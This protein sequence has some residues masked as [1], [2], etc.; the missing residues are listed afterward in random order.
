MISDIEVSIQIRQHHDDGQAS[1]RTIKTLTEIEEIRNI[2]STWQSNPISDIDNFLLLAR[3][4][5]EIQRPHVMVVY[6]NG[7]PDCVLVGRMEY[8]PMNFK[9]GY[10]KVFESRVKTLCFMHGGFL[11]NQSAENSDFL[12]REIM[13]ALKN[14]EADVARMES[15]RTDSSLG[16]A[17]TRIPGV[18]CR[19]HFS[20]SEIHGCL[21]LP[22]SYQAFLSSLPR[23]ERQNLKRYEKRLQA[24]FSGS[25]RIRCFRRESEIE[26]L[27]RDAEEIAKKTYQRGLGVGFADTPET[28]ETIQMA[29]RRGTLRACVL[30]LAARPCAFMIGAQYRDT[31][32]GNFLAFDPQFST[33]APGSLLLMHWI[34]E[35]FEANGKQQISQIDLGSG[36]AR[37]KRMICNLDWNESH[38]HIFAPTFTSLKLNFQRSLCA[39]LHGAA[40][41]L[42]AKTGILEKVKKLWRSRGC[43]SGAGILSRLFHTEFAF[44]NNNGDKLSETSTES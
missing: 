16:V 17:A 7:D 35:A 5:P 38:I 37:Y 30:Y 40:L 21:Q 25:M 43:N 28:R 44:R 3:L 2:W 11:G 15:V 31:Q 27:I 23:K 36:D 39:L 20:L 24:D 8:A 41:R 14:K 13:K 1:L 18:L 10:H 4:R 29:A 32:H 26:E 33:Y 19:D 12:I 9:V 34:E 22:N 42:A 6:R